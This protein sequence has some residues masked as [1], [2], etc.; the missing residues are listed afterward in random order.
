MTC[1]LLHW[2]CLTNDL[3]AAGTGDLCP[4]PAM[5][6]PGICPG[7]TIAKKKARTARDTTKLALRTERAALV[8]GTPASGRFSSRNQLARSNPVDITFSERQTF[9]GPVSWLFRH[10]IGHRDLAPGHPPPRLGPVGLAFGSVRQKERLA[11]TT[12]TVV[13]RLAP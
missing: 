12:P 11:R 3:R 9:L 6:P 7:L 10:F 4:L 2:P 1:G 5:P 13:V 8:Y